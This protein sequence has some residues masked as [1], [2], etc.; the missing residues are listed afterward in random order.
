MKEE[1]QSYEK[2]KK[3]K[4]TT[5]L[6]RSKLQPTKE[7]VEKNSVDMGER[8]KSLEFTQDQLDE[9]LGNVKEEIEKLY[10]NIKC[11]EHDLLN[12]D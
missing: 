1:L 2:K 10:P 9:E 12:P 5:E 8:A 4:Q 3:K 11:V 6:I 7:R